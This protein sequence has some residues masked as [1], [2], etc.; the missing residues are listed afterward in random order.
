MKLPRRFALSTLLLV[1][2]LVALV[3]GYAQWRRLRLKAE[4]AALVSECDPMMFSLGS[5]PIQFEDHW[6][7]PTVS[8]R[9][10]IVIR[11]ES[12][13]ALFANGKQLSRAEAKAYWE[14][15]A[16]RLRA[17]GVSDISYCLMTISSVPNKPRMQ[18]TMLDSVDEL[19]S[20]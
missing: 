10:A 15:K 1:M 18:V 13:G 6:F 14:A 9:A 7:W 16:A 5:R 2:L 19:D 12:D 3:C 11:E 17:I 8:D 20:R 4:V